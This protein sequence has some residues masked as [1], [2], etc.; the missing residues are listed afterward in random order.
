MDA[1]SGFMTL[2]FPVE[3]AE[4]AE[5]IR[6][7]IRRTPVLRTELDGRPLVLKLEHLQRTGSFKLRGALNALLS[8]QRPKRVVTVSGGN[9]GIGVATAAALFGVPATV[10]AM[11]STPDSK[12]ARI[13]AAGGV[14]ERGGSYDEAVAAAHAVEDA[15]FIH[16][17]NDLAVIAGQGT[18]AAELVDE[19]PE[20]D[21][22]AVSVG[23]GGLAAGTALGSGGRRVVCVEPE[24]CSCFH[25]AL[26]QGRPVGAEVVS[27]AASSL[28]A[29]RVGELPF[30]IL[31]GHG[32]E[33]VLVTEDEIVAAQDR[34][35]TEFRLTVEPAAAVPFAAWQKAAIPGQ[36]PAIILCGANI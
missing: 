8:G 26:A 13:E 24:R 22:I 33:S 30:E 23:G 3:V 6:P 21:A 16:P 2:T 20:V 11:P 19:V 35:W 18:V 9:H 25:Q 12:V 1:H 27:V 5:R 4:A 31:T 32:A 14:V 17:F 28:G 29:P 34:L 7:Y 15:L 36:L 10:F